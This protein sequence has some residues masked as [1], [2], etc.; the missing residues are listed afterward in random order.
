MRGFALTVLPHD[1]KPMALID[2]EVG[3]S[4]Q[5][6]DRSSSSVPQARIDKATIRT[7]CVRGNVAGTQDTNM[8]D[9]VAHDPAAGE[10]ML[11]MVETRPWGLM[12]IKPTN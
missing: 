3:A 11:V 12:R 8:I 9:V 7:G 10:Y 6:I 1:S 2:Q 5:F 4:D